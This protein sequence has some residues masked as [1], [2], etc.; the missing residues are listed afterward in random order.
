MQQTAW[1]MV[2]KSMRAYDTTQGF[3]PGL[4]DHRL[5]ELSVRLL[6]CLSNHTASPPFGRYQIILRGNR[7]TCV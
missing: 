5:P 1:K 3:G 2:V 4:S 6:D 7:G